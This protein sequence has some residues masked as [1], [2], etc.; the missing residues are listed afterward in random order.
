MVRGDLVEEPGRL[1]ETV[2]PERRLTEAEQELRQIERR[3]Q[4]SVPLSV[5]LAVWVQQH[6]G[7]RPDLKEPL[8]NRRAGRV[9]GGDLNWD[10]VLIDR[11]N[12]RDVTVGNGLQPLTSASGRREEVEQDR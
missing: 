7:R 3:R 5:D 12:D 8:D 9:H 6:Q 11:C 1:L 10:D 2:L 4:I